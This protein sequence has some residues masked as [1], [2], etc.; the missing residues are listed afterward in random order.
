MTDNL[1]VI[2]VDDDN[3]IVENLKIVLAAKGDIEVVGTANNGEEALLL[4]ENVKAD[5][6]LVDLKMPVM[7]GTQLIR[8]LSEKYPAMKKLVLTTFCD[9]RDI[10]EAI[11]NGADSYITKDLSDKL[12]SS[13]KLLRQGQCIF[14]RRVLEWIRKSVRKASSDGAISSD[15]LFKELTAR[16]LFICGIIAEGFTNSEIA[17]QLFITE[18]TV[19]NYISSIYEKTGIHNRTQLVMALQNN[20]TIRLKE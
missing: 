12:M 9:D 3:D 16:E 5:L 2:I 8:A 20:L 11:V 1:R 17:K 10:A 14:D 7:S 4:L 18:G 15:V 6:A 13:I 19:K